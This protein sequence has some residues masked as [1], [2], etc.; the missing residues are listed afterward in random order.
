MKDICIRVHVLYFRLFTRSGRLDN[1]KLPFPRPPLNTHDT[2]EERP[3]RRSRDVIMLYNK[4][5]LNLRNPNSR[6]STMWAFMCLLLPVPWVFGM[7]STWIR[8]S[9]D[10]FISS[11]FSRPIY[12]YLA[13]SLSPRSHSP[14]PPFSRSFLCSP[15]HALAALSFQIRHVPLPVKGPDKSTW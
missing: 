14:M 7:C 13:R 5:A 8:V 3:R 10:S 2:R 1:Y 6:S 9:T 15:S 11:H 12:L 4:L